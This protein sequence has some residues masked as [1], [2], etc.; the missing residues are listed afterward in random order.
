MGHPNLLFL[1]FRFFYSLRTTRCGTAEP[2]L[3]EP[4]TGIPGSPERG[5]NVERVV[6]H[7]PAPQHAVTTCIRRLAPTVGIIW[8]IIIQCVYPLKDIT[9]HVQY[10]IGAGAIRVAANLAGFTP[11]IFLEI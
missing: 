4:N 7:R 2:V 8:V 10:T 3:A 11:T 9:G 6:A 1:G 5:A